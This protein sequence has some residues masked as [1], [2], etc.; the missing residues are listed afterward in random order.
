MTLRFCICVLLSLGVLVAQENLLRNGGFEGTGE[1]Y[2][3]RP[4]ARARISGALATGWRDN[5]EWA[6]LELQYA[7]DTSV[8][9]GGTASQRME[10]RTAAS[11]SPQLWQEF[12][13]RAGFTYTGRVWVRAPERLPVNLLL[14]TSAAPYT[15]HARHQVLTT[16]DWQEL[17]VTWTATTDSRVSFILNPEAAGIVWFD[18]ADLSASVEKSAVAAPEAIDPAQ[19]GDGVNLL[20]NP[21]FTE[22]Y[23]TVDA[24]EGEIG[25]VVA[26]GWEDNS[27]WADVSVR[28]EMDTLNARSGGACQQLTV[29]SVRNGVVQ[30][31]QSFEMRR[32]RQYRAEVWVR[33]EVSMP[34][35]IIVRDAT[36]PWQVHASSQATLDP[37]WRRVLLEWTA[38]KDSPVYLMI[39]PQGTGT[40]F[41]DEATLADVTGLPPAVNSAPPKLGNL[42]VNSSFE[43]GLAND[44]MLRVNQQ[45][46]AMTSEAP[47][48]CAENPVHG[49]H[50]LSF[51]A[52]GGPLHTGGSP[53]DLATPSVAVNW[54]RPHVFSIWLRAERPVEVVQLRFGGGAERT[55]S[56]DRE[57]RQYSMSATPG[58]GQTVLGGHVRILAAEDTRIWADA[59][60]IEEATSP[61][62]TYQQP[63]AIEL[64]ITTDRSGAIFHADEAVHLRVH[65]ATP[66][67]AGS[68][69][70]TRVYDLYGTE[71]VQLPEASL[72]VTSLRIPADATRPLGVFRLV[73][74]IVG[75]DG[76][77]L[78]APTTTQFARLP[79]PLEIAPRESFFGIHARF[80]DDGIAIARA[81]GM[82]W[83]RVHDA[84]PHFTKWAVAEPE[85]DRFRFYD[86]PVDQAL[87]AGLAILGMLDGAPHWASATPR[88]SS[89]YFSMWNLPDGPDALARWDQ[90]VTTLATHYRGRID[91]WEVWN[92]PWVDLFFPGGTP[93]LYADLMRRANVHAKAANPA[94][95]IVGISTADS[96]DDFTQA[97]LAAA[98]PDHFDVL[99]FHAYIA[100]MANGADNWATANANKYRAMQAVHGQAKPVWLTEGGPGPHWQS[101]PAAGALAAGAWQN[102]S[103]IVRADVALM[104]AGIERFFVYSAAGRDPAGLIGHQMLHHDGTI[105]PALAARAVLAATIDG[106]KPLERTEPVPGLV[107]CYAFQRRDGGL[108][109]VLWSMDNLKHQ[110]AVQAG[111][112]AS[113]ML[114]N[115]LPIQHGQVSVGGHPIYLR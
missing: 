32:G 4:D 36:G 43:A 42:L 84:A 2:S 89:G 83:L 61:S 94:A 55:V 92:E 67:P 45:P 104:S 97:V 110:V 79:R 46:G 17:R 39:M 115:P 74:T 3:P 101:F 105:K 48:R 85:R 35:N 50:A 18:D 9:R 41:I 30:F 34:V 114:G 64:A 72:P 22:P 56:I 73:S 12:E 69:L 102:M 25:G 33:A 15:L 11:G 58:E 40:M 37:A 38:T 53:A 10:L 14:R 109:H 27:A 1:A 63:H 8:H 88:A 98:G 13:A 70:R 76:A 91:H 66:A 68:V 52:A 103:W 99:S 54:G 87:A 80:D 111:Q 71:P 77:L 93:E 107:E 47:E 95:R 5:S 24:R 106:A 49:T 29:R 7:I 59:A 100:G 108:V 57:W 113:D 44:W 19:R 62:A 65:M 86:A 96:K 82:R 16:P 31:A 28:Y 90:Y 81:T 26:H 112:V 51:V 75:P 78:S 21:H 20:R 60:Q 6:D 23:T